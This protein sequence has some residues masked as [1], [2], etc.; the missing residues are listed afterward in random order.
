MD[1][2][3]PKDLRVRLSLPWYLKVTLFVLIF[4]FRLF[5]RFKYPLI[6]DPDIETVTVGV[7]NVM[8]SMHPGTRPQKG[9]GLEEHFKKQI[10]K[11]RM[12]LPSGFI[13]QR[14]ATMSFSGDLM[15]NDFI[16]ASINKFYKNVE[17]EVFDN[18]ISVAN[19]ESTLTSEQIE[20]TTYSHKT[21]PKINATIEDYN[22]MKGHENKQFSIFMLSNNHILDRGK[23]GWETTIKKLENDGIF[24]FGTNKDAEAQK[25]GLLVE[26]NGIKFGFVGFTSSLNLHLMPEGVPFAVNYIKFHVP[27]VEPDLTLVKTQI[28]DLKSKGCDLVIVSLHWGI[29][30]EFFPNPRQVRIAHHLAEAGADLILCHHTHCIQP[31]EFY[32]TERDPNRIVPIVYSLGNLS[33]N[34]SNPHIVLSMISLTEIAKGT[35]NGEQKTFIKFFDL[36]PVFQHEIVNNTEDSRYIQLEKLRDQIDLKHKD[37]QYQKYVKKI[38]EY[39]D[40]VI[41]TNWRKN[42]K[43]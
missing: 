31:Y 36:I 32:Q 26:K 1:N 19:L 35:I 10:N 20:Q 2:K 37:K 8:R 12:F 27:K 16:G 39:A 29:E 23:E 14:T 11:P 6:H 40:F 4:F 43:V 18:D 34:K 24:H 7:Y 9:S 41:G 28:K 30:Y 22:A 5:N 38:A 25:T 15:K 3:T 13:T 21:M 42:D 33:A 17:K